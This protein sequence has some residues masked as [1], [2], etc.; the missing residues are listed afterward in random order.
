VAFNSDKHT[1]VKGTYNLQ[2]GINMLRE[3]EQ[4][5]GDINRF[6]AYLYTFECTIHNQAERGL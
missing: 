5:V 1:P 4:L 3:T 2:S 6:Q